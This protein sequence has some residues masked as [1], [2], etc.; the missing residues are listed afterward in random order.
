MLT[1]EGESIS[2]LLNSYPEAVL[3]TSAIC[4]RIAVFLHFFSVTMVFQ[5]PTAVYES[6]IEEQENQVA[7]EKVDV[8][9]ESPGVTRGDVR[10]MLS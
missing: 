9:D 2:S 8:G 7:I 10:R 1:R 3:A 5:A 4:L 6:R